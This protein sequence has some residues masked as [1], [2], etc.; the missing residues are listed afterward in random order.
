MSC[1]PVE[2]LPGLPRSQSCQLGHP[3]L[4]VS[5][6]RHSGICFHPS[7]VS[8]QKR[9]IKVKKLLPTYSE[10]NFMFRVLYVFEKD[11]GLFSVSLS[12]VTGE[13]LK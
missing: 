8:L 5:L 12:I 2:A 4:F 7:V 10:N 3:C 6:T 1:N 13:I 11:N 9:N